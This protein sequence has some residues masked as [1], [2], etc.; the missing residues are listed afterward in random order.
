[1]GV[2][3]T[4]HAVYAEDAAT[5]ALD[6]LA[7]GVTLLATMHLDKSAPLLDLLA[8]PDAQDRATQGLTREANLDMGDA[9]L[10]AF[11]PGDTRTLRD[12]LRPELLAERLAAAPPDLFATNP[13]YPF[14]ATDKP[15][16]G[17]LTVQTYAPRLAAFLQQAA[18]A[19]H[20]LFGVTT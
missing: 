5:L 16:D 8:F 1:M 3:T 18:D 17:T 2:S 4:L 20:G 15:S 13:T 14:D 11:S 19:G 12:A 10:R 6:P 7:G 9:E